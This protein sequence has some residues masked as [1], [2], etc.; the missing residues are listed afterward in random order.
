MKSTLRIFT[1]IYFV[2]AFSIQ[3]VFSQQPKNKKS[4]FVYIQDQ[5]LHT[6]DGKPFLMQG[7]NLGY[8]LNPEG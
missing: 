5:N 6:P 2:L 4:K 8:W 3:A 1:L 7:I